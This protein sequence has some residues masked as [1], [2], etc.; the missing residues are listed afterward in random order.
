[1][2][3]ESLEL[4]RRMY[5]AFHARDFDRALSYFSGDVLVDGSKARPDLSIGKGRKYVDA[6]VSSW[7][8]AWEEWSEEIEEM[9]ALGSQ[10]LVLSVHRGQ[11]KG[12]GVQLEAP[13]FVL[14]DVRGGEITSMRMYRKL[15]DALEAAGLSE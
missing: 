9:R 3:Q 10:V 8:G 15:S 14:Y 13:H 6:M 5:D 4:V 1:M 11:G 12:S 7:V 2:S